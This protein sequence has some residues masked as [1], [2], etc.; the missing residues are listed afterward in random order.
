MRA[1]YKS[2]S[3]ETLMIN[4]NAVVFFCS[5][6]LALALFHCSSLYRLHFIV[7]EQ[8]VWGHEWVIFKLPRLLAGHMT[9]CQFVCVSISLALFVCENGTRLFIYFSSVLFVH[10]KTI[11]E[12]SSFANKLYFIKNRSYLLFGLLPHHVTKAFH[13]VMFALNV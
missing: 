7:L 2:K 10:N 1:R 8:G 5:R 4:G 12:S 3:N 13:F 6:L 9:A 11:S